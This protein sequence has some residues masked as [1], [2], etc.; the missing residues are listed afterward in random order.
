MKDVIDK[1]YLNKKLNSK[2]GCGEIKSI[3]TSLDYLHH[4]RKK[5]C[6]DLSTWTPIVC[7]HF[8]KR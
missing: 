6:N 7:C 3:H 5:N 8:H 1:P 2:L 4:L